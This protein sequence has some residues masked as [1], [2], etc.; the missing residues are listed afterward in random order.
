MYKSILLHVDASAHSA[1][2]LPLTQALAMRHEAHLT[3]L[4]GATPTFG[5]VSFGFSDGT[6][7]RAAAGDRGDWRAQAK[8]RLEEAMLDGPDV[9]WS[10]LPLEYMARAF[11][12]EAMYADLVVLGQ[13]AN[14]MDQPGEAPAGFV[15]S[16]LM[17]GGR[18]ALL[19]PRDRAV[20]TAG[21]RVL[22]AW[23]ASPNAARAVSGALPLLRY[24]TEVEVVTWSDDPPIGRYS[25]VDIVEFLRRH[26][27][28]AHAQQRASTIHVGEAI[29]ARAQ[30]REDDLVVM[31]CSGRSGARER[32]LG[33]ATRSLLA[34]MP[35][36]VLMAY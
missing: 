34:K 21:S 23:N 1:V 15:E 3:A 32:A 29:I 5:E 25:N 22:V 30:E 8:A 2:R 6:M 18:P 24:A 35:V 16:V 28:R 10:E 7:T 14:G 31:G 26:G 12:R 20:P 17:D 11:V 33:G 27:V 36:P 9:G 4:F 13:P 19:I